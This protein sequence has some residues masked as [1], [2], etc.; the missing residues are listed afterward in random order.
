LSNNNFESSPMLEGSP[1]G[2]KEF[3]EAL[4]GGF[5]KGSVVLLAGSSGSGKT[6]FSFE[7]L[8]NG[9]KQGE[10]S[11]Y[12]TLTEPLFNTLKNLETFS[13]YDREAI[14]SESLKIIDMRD[15]IFDPKGFDYEKVLDFIEDEITSSGATR[16]VIDSVTAIAYT[17]NNKA[18]I[19][20]FIFELGKIL[21]TLGCTTILTSEVAD[22]NSYS[23]FSVEEF[24]SDVILRCDR[25][26]K[27]NQLLR[28]I[29]IIKVRGKETFMG[30]LD[31]RIT[32]EGI[33][34]IPPLD[35]KM[36]AKATSER[37]SIG[38][39]DVD[40]LLFGGVLKGSS[41]MLA[42]TTG[43][44]K[45]LLS[46]SFIFDGLKK[47]EHCLYVGFEESRDQIVRNA[48]AFGWDL[49]P[50]E[51]KGL[52]II[53]SSYPHEKLLEEHL[54]DIKKIV[55]SKKISRCVVDSLSAISNSHPKKD[56]LS[57][58]RRLNG[59]LKSDEVT[60]IFTLVS[61]AV[62]SQTI[63]AEAQVSTLTDNLIMLRHV[64]MEGSLQPVMNIVKI[65]GSDHSKDLIEY[66]ITS[67]GLKIGHNLSGFEGILTGVSRKVDKTIEEKVYAEFKRF[68]GDLADVMFAKVQEK[69]LTGKNVIKFIDDISSQNIL[70]SDQLTFFKDNIKEIFGPEL[71]AS[72]LT[73]PETKKVIS[74][75]FEDT[76]SSQKKSFLNKYFGKDGSKK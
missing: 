41:T 10:K 72:E 34:V 49:K 74:E 32:S 76:D 47:G 30:S 17:I 19:R 24:I 61:S 67:K 43:T 37:I 28:T 53:R 71:I 26:K 64:E 13:F 11:I 42:G 3:D 60:S 68:L 65:R 75:F 44:G 9:V 31:F 45:S 40:K 14:E 5:P 18:H 15:S 21:A 7:W 38:N 70:K 12:I 73:D 23:M 46:L 16:L 58:A 33:K 36:T 48:A 6:I 35:V 27:D 55:E 2:I 8:F 59:F 25:I 4:K 29:S 50:F 69:G 56:F 20:Q 39:E 52:L 1:T 66:S 57:F 63:S 51:K 54:A 62:L 22:E